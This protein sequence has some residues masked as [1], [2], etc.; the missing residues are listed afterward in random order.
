MTAN[1]VLSKNS[2][3]VPT[4]EVCLLTLQ[5][6]KMPRN[7]QTLRIP[8]RTTPSPQHHAYRCR[9]MPGYLRSIQYP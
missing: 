1:T 8:Y 9:V 5:E 7:R 6:S 2:P 3:L 4:P